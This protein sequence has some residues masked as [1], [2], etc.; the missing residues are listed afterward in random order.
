VTPWRGHGD[1]VADLKQGK[2]VIVDPAMREASKGK[3]HAA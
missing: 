1:W 3:R 2:I